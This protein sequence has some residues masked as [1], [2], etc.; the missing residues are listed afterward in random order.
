MLLIIG[1]AAFVALAA[2]AGIVTILAWT[3]VT[4]DTDSDEPRDN[5]P[6][7]FF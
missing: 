2:V 1:D 6:H 5:G 3:A 7:R 4:F